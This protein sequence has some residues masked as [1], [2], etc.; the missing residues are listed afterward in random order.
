MKPRIQVRTPGRLHFGLNSLGH[1]ETRPQFGG[2]GVMVDSPGVQLEI[3]HSERFEVHGLQSERV[4]KFAA[5]IVE[6]LRLPG[7]PDVSIKVLASP[8][9]HVGLGVGTQL[10]LAVA[11]GFAEALGFPWRDP[12]R[13]AQ[14]TRR[15]RRSAIGTYGFLRGGF[16]VDGGH[17]K[18]EP[19]GEL[20][21]RDELPSE[22]RFA[23]LIPRDQS[24]C[25]GPQEESAFSDLPAVSIS[26]TDELEQ[27]AHSH[28]IP[29][30][31]ERDFSAFSEA[32]YHYGCLAGKCFAEM[33]GGIFSSPRT[34]DLI[35]WLREQE[36]AG[37]GQSSWGPT[38][39][40]L[41]PNEGAAERLKQSLL[42][43]QRFQEYEITVARPANSGAIVKVGE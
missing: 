15:G 32:L 29:A 23:L 20:T 5:S 25:F 8:S 40:A 36:I 19:I 21:H 26:T 3:S 7:L 12:V 13:L 17:F 30:L 39:F 27:L 42:Q 31:A 43:D 41:L 22:W 34:A 10:G 24:G 4:T 16:I 1:D 38:V 11:A 14:L 9:E 33:Q 2:V 37:V 28:L 35:T 6:Q 18:N